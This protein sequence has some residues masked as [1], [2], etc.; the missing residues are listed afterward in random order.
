MS[1]I[2]INLLANRSAQYWGRMRTRCMKQTLTWAN[3]WDGHA[4]FFAGRRSV[5][6]E[7]AIKHWGL[8]RCDAILNWNRQRRTQSKDIRIQSNSISSLKN[9]NGARKKTK[10]TDT[11]LWRFSAS[12][13]EF[14]TTRQLLLAGRGEEASG[15][16]MLG[17]LCS[18][19]TATV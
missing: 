10:T 4:L 14:F 7:G 18:K 16:S 8:G 6:G 2:W 13:I 17:S 1:S 12:L 3:D 15:S 11:H 9:T 19:E 5:R